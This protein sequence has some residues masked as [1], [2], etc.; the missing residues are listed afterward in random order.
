[1]STGDAVQPGARGWCV[2]WPLELLWCQ[3][4]KA[5]ALVKQL[6]SPVVPQSTGT[7]PCG[8]TGSG[9]LSRHLCTIA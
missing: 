8:C 9:L 4:T 7:V 5:L 3:C 2:P 1:M 6:G